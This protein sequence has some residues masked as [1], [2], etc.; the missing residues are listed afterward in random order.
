MLTAIGS[1]VLTPLSWKYS[2]TPEDNSLAKLV[3]PIANA[4]TVGLRVTAPKTR[5]GAIC[6]RLSKD[7]L[8][9]TPKGSAWNAW[10]ACFAV[11]TSFSNS[12]PGLALY[13]PASACED[14]T[15]FCAS[16]CCACNDLI[17]ASASSG[18]KGSVSPVTGSRGPAL[19]S[20]IALICF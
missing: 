1:L 18:W 7:T 8:A 2:I 11:V 14:I 20:L 12:T 19:P 10:N 5:A 6:G 4:P 9:M 17:A 16:A 15:F 13:L 3:L